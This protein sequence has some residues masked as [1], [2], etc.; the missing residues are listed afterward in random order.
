LGMEK[1]IA[2]Q[3][4]RATILSAWAAAKPKT[5]GGRC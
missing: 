3:I 5:S 4:T 2:T 1:P